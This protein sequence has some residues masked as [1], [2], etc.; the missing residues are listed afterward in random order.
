LKAYVVLD[1]VGVG[2]MEILRCSKHVSCCNFSAS[3]IGLMWLSR[4]FMRWLSSVFLSR[5]NLYWLPFW[6]TKLA[7]CRLVKWICSVT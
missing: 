5:S 4:I 6:V 7:Y 1:D 3:S 2:N